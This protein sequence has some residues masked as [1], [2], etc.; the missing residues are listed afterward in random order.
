MTLQLPSLPFSLDPLMAEAKRRA[1]QRRLLVAVGV[2]LTVGLAVGLTFALRPHGGGTSGRP[3][4]ARYPQDG[5][6]FRYPSGMTNVKLCGSYGN[7]LTGDVAPIADLTTGE[8]PPSCSV[9][10][11]PDMWPPEGRLGTNGV[12]IVLARVELWPSAYQP[13]WHGRLGTWRTAYYTIWHNTHPTS[14]CP[15]SVQHETRSVAIRRNDLPEVA[16]S[17]PLRPEVVSVDALICGP[18]FATGRAT[19]DQVVSSLR[20]TK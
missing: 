17:K 4:T 16:R 20:F 3:A 18:S 2:V 12:R 15:L 14:G 7:G 1:R 9:G 8:A 19:F 5:I 13:N 11:V 10:A 6:S